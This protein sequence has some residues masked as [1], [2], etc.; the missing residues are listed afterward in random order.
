ME[1]KKIL[2]TGATG[3]LGYHVVL[4]LLKSEGYQVYAI[5]GRPEDRANLLPEHPRIKAFPLAS[6]FCEKWDNIDTVINCAFARSNDPKLLA[7]AIDFTEKEIGVFEDMKVKSVIN[8]S[9]QGVY[10]RLPIGE[11][12]DE[13]S[14]IE[15]ID[16]YSMAKY[17]VEGMFRVSCVPYTTSVRLASLMMPQRFLHFFVKKAK[18]GE[19][20]TVT[21][22]N[23]CAAL[24]DVRDAASGLVAIAN[25]P[26]EV[27]AETYNLGIGCQYSLLQYAES[28]KSIGEA[29]GFHVKYDV[30]DDGTTSCAGMDCTRIMKDTGWKPFFMK[31]RMVEN[32]FEDMML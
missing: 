24:L 9:S 6:L 13:D 12:S 22:P 16:L 29:L 1:L 2:V 14:P 7:D 23:Q 4:E 21:A 5:G 26:P 3:Y 20:F 18:A 17:A 25:L 19:A 15:P 30:A 31:D 11:L 32:L 8:I 28:V 27:W 10:Q